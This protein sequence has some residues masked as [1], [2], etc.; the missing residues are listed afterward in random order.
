METWSISIQQ[1]RI[2]SISI[3]HNKNFTNVFKA[4]SASINAG[5]TWLSSWRARLYWFYTSSFYLSTILFS[6]S[7]LFLFY[8]ASYFSRSIFLP[9]TSVSAIDYWSIGCIFII[10]AVSSSTISLVFL[11]FSLP[12]ISVFLRRDY[13]FSYEF[14]R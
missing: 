5:R 3:I 1:C 4:S 9:I 12:I 8:E 7:T 13:V 2:N 11:S 14:I 6:Y 10:L